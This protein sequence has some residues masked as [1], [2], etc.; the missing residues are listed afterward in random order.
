MVR[1]VIL[2]QYTSDCPD[3]VGRAKIATASPL[4]DVAEV[5]ALAEAVKVLLWTNK[6]IQNVND[7]YVAVSDEYDSELAMVADLLQRLPVSGRYLNSEWCENGKGGVAACDAYE[8][9]R[10]DPVPATGRRQK[11]RYF[12]KFAIGKTGQLLLTASCHLC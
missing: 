1:R 4:Y 8:V 6:C 2:S 7:L 12:V 10:E 5:T 11:T 9:S 3:E